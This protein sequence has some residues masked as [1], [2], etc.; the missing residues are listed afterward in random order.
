[1]RV[2]TALSAFAAMAVVGLGLVSAAPAVAVSG[3]ASHPVAAVQAADGL[4]IH[5]GKYMTLGG[6]QTAGQQGIER[7][8]WDR[9]QCAEGS[10]WPWV[11]NLWTNR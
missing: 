6:C 8:H 7:G 10:A 9:Y 5:R 4:D 1:M 3:A 11:W 2:R